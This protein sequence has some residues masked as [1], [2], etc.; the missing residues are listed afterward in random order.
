MN[1]TQ[2]QLLSTENLIRWEGRDIVLERRGALVNDGAGGRLTPTT[3]LVLVESQRL[4]FGGKINN[5]MNNLPTETYTAAGEMQVVR[6]VLIGM[7][8]ADI[9]EH[10]EFELDGLRW[11]VEF[12]DADR[13]FQ[14]L[15]EC[16]HVGT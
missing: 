9:V 12:L 5:R 7:P 11:K 1:R 10:D 13:T 15:A 2:A 3:A 4:Y 14:T 6:N 8:E 16:T